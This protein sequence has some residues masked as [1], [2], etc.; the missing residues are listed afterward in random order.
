M[1]Y[2]DN[3]R[4]GDYKTCP[5]KYFLR[6][7]LDLV[8][9]GTA[10][11]LIFGLSWHDSMDVVWGLGQ[12][13]SID[14]TELHKK[15]VQKFVECWRE[16][17]MPFPIPME[18]TGRFGFRTPMV[19]AEMLINY[20]EQRL[21][22]IRNC[23]IL[24]IEQPFAVDIF[25][26]RED[27]KYIG[28]FDKVIRH[29]QYGILVIE[30]K[31]TSAYAKASGFRTDYVQSWSPNSQIDGYL[32][33]AHMLYG[34]AVRGVWVDAALVHKTVHNKFRFIPVD[35]QFA[36][37]DAWLFETRNWIERIESEEQSDVPVY[38]RYPKNTGSCNHY[39]GCSY[40]D[41]CKFFVDPRECRDRHDGYKVDHWEPFDILKIEELGLEKEKTNG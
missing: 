24:A 4:V 26:D 11:A 32:H 10:L 20:I 16:H 27:V 1:K 5:R 13:R 37:L 35:R 29:P 8:P 19:A 36:A 17:D 18:Q 6:H 21:D 31:T 15:A 39:A 28:R 14:R 7:K 41:L 25:G 33:A 23:E 22:F 38:Q 2:Y 3:T 12:D 34:K 9:E 40:R 30:H